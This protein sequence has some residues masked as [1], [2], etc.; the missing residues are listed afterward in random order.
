MGVNIVKDATTKSKKRK[1]SKRQKLIQV[2]KKF[3]ANDYHCGKVGH[4]YAYSCA[5]IKLKDKHKIQANIV[6][7]MEDADDISVTF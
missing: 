7:D 3:K 1:K 5:Q 6:E 2:K 4:K